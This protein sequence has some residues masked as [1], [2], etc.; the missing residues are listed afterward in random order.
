M[1]LTHQLHRS[2]K[3][4]ILNTLKSLLNTKNG[5]FLSKFFFFSSFKEDFDK[6]LDDEF[7]SCVDECL[8]DYSEDIVPK[9]RKKKRTYIERGREEGDIRLRNDYFSEHAIYPASIFRRQFRMN[10]SLFVRIVDELSTGI[11]YFQQKP[12]GSGR[13]GL[14]GLQKCT[15]A[16]HMMAYGT[17]ADAIDEYLR[18][19]ETTALKCFA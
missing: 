5:I 18:M 11:P 9:K 16:I 7:E 17:A 13:L 6:A 3:K 10:R 1:R 15:A 8:D 12:D 14:S 19:G 4:S 2:T